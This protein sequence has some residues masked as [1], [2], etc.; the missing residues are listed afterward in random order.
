MFDYLADA[1]GI[2]GFALLVAK[3]IGARYDRRRIVG[4]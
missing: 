1:L 3:F 4:H 2:F